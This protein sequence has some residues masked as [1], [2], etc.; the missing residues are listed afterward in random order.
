M[1]IKFKSFPVHFLESRKH[2]QKYA[3]NLKRREMASD[4]KQM[5]QNERYDGDDE[6]TV[7]RSN[8]GRLSR[9]LGFSERVL[10]ERER[11]NHWGTVTSVV[12]LDSKRE[13]NQDHLRK[14]LGLLTKR[15]TLSRMRINE[16]G[17]EACFEEMDSTDTVDF[18]VLDG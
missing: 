2:R 5:D 16:S 8:D 11:V 4:K 15:F 17:S 3:K 7:H 1:L 10:L 14:A 12:L 9:P 18:Q 13:L 6:F